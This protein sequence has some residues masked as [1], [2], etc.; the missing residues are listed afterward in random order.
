M[1]GVCQGFCVIFA[2]LAGLTPAVGSVAEPTP[3]PTPAP[4]RVSI[5]AWK[6]VS[7]PDLILQQ[8]SLASKLLLHPGWWAGAQV[9]G[10]LPDTDVFSTSLTRQLSGVIPVQSLERL[11][12]VIA[13]TPG[14]VPAAFARAD[15]VL[16]LATERVLGNAEELARIVA[17]VVVAGT[18][19]PAP[20]ETGVSEPLMAAAEALVAGGALTLAALPPALRPVSA[21]ADRR[22]AGAALAGFFADL[23]DEERGWS[24]RRAVLQR[25]QQPGGAPPA[26]GT[27]A[28][29]L[30]ETFGDLERARREPMEL[31]RFW[32]TTR[33]PDLPSIPRPVRRLLAEPDRAGLPKRSERPADLRLL[34]TNA[35]ERRL[36]AADHI[37]EPP[38][39][40]ILP[41]ALYLTAAARGRA[42][43]SP[44]VCAWLERVALPAGVRTGCPGEVPDGGIVFVRA[45]RF[46]GTEVV[47]RAAGGGEIVLVIW[48]RWALFPVVA[49]ERN[50]LILVDERGLWE[51]ALEGGVEPR[52]LL[53]G[54]FRHVSVTP[55]GNRLAV[56]EWPEGGIVVKEDDAVR[57]LGIAARAGTLWLEEDVMLAAEPDSLFLVSAAGDRQPFPVEVECLR[58]LSGRGESV[59]VGTADPCDPMLERFSLIDPGRRETLPVPGGAGGMALLPDGSVV[60]SAADGLARWPGGERVERLAAGLTPGPG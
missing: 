45:H 49:A 57:H 42:I 21:W 14:E 16:V 22:D 39:D 60:F 29:L 24:S 51:I 46:G 5:T 13:Q 3:A 8:P 32:L 50:V 9:P 53:E 52:L 20:P 47:S 40:L 1:D 25:F 27:A 2:L 28:A 43:G 34:E 38:E 26:V 12:V 48:P 19:T 54:S 10:T 15:L 31:L 6:P 37:G 33:H 44:H 7:F 55:S 17:P 36:E 18:F 11:Q 23:D 56:V 58:F 4:A 35:F 41:E 59:V 30:L